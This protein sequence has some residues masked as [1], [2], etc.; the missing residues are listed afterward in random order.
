MYLIWQYQSLNVHNVIT[1]CHGSVRSVVSYTVRRYTTYS[2][3]F[4]Q[5]WQTGV[6]KVLPGSIFWPCFYQLFCCREDYVSFYPTICSA[7]EKKN[8][9]LKFIWRHIH[10]ARYQRKSGSFSPWPE[11]GV[12]FADI[13][14]VPRWVRARR[15]ALLTPLKVA[16]FWDSG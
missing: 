16:K 3:M 6:S 15:S 9:R 2:K 7:V 12:I 1:C 8:L 4:Q 5:C 10:G 13:D 11:L 14:G